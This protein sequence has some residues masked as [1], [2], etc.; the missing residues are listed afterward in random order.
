MIIAINW[1]ADVGDMVTEVGVPLAV[2]MLGIAGSVFVAALSFAMGRWAE[3]AARRRDGY[4]AAKQTLVSY[5]EYCWRIRRRTSD[6]PEELRRLADIGHDIQ[7][8]LAYHQLWTGAEDSFVGK[9]F[10]EVRA[11]LASELAP[12]CRAAWEQP[13]IATAQDM[14]LGGEWGP[15]VDAHLERFDSAVAFRFGWRR[16]LG[17]LHLHLGIVPRPEPRAASLSDG[18]RNN[19]A[20]PRSAERSGCSTS[21]IEEAQANLPQSPHG[22]T[23]LDAPAV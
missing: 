2:A 3:A 14:V 22:A 15:D 4:S 21:T 12:A 18:T 19:I 5:R 17:I 11:D 9:V 7:E 13:P 6:D 23:T 8:Q 16:L 10:R 20:G 1:G